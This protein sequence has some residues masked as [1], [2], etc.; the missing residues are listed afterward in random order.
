LKKK[1]ALHSIETS[2]HIK[3]RAAW[4]DIA[5]HQT[6]QISQAE[7]IGSFSYRTELTT[8]LQTHGTED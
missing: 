4:R 1:K 2:E 7:N 3:L 6:S 8:S 5:E